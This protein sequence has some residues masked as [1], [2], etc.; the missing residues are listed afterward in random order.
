MRL[1]FVH[2]RFQ[3]MVIVLLVALSLVAVIF[4]YSFPRENNYH[5]AKEFH[6]LLAQRVHD[7]IETRLNGSIMLS[8]A[9]AKNP[10]LYELLSKETVYSQDEFTEMMRLWLSGIKESGGYTTAYLVS[11]KTHSYYSAEGIKRILDPY[12]DSTD[13]WY[14]TFIGKDVD[15]TLEVDRDRRNYEHWTI[16]HNARIED[17]DG[18]LLGVCGVGM[19]VSDLQKLFSE[20]EQN[21]NVK[22]NLV[23]KDGVVQV[24]TNTVSIERTFYASQFFSNSEDY[25]YT[26]RRH[27]YLVTTFIKDLN[28]YLVVQNLPT[29]GDVHSMNNM[30]LLSLGGVLLLLIAAVCV[31]FAMHPEWKIDTTKEPI[32]FLTGLYNRNYF[33]DVYGEHGVLNTTRY[34]SIA[35]FDIDFF[36]EANDSM[37]GD[38]ILKSVTSYARDIFGEQNEIFRWGGDEFAVLMSQQISAAYDVCRKFCVAIAQAGHVTVSVGVTEIRLAD[39]VKKNYYR[40]AQNCYLVKEMGGNGVK[41]S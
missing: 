21:F 33:K 34:K 29:A 17:D 26:A 4:H 27:G 13:F 20:Y 30:F 19:F 2:H 36:K 24:D 3:V 8:K 10:L 38:V 40:A 32:D 16:F 25:I 35:V 18:N 11:E 31:F 28:W 22:I 41:R 14:N 7:A 23:N 5:S 12:T 6:I 1:H 39:S 15:F 37:N 9:M